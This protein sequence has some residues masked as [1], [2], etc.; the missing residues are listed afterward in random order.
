MVKPHIIWGPNKRFLRLL[1]SIRSRYLLEE[2]NLFYL[3]FTIKRGRIGMCLLLVFVLEHSTLF[4]TGLTMAFLIIYAVQLE[5][6]IRSL[7]DLLI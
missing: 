2:I 5:G 6:G 4:T 1:K 7:I 3:F